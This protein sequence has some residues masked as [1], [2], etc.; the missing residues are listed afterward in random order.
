MSKTSQP[1]IHVSCIQS[2]GFVWKWRTQRIWENLAVD[3]HFPMFSP[4][5][6]RHL[7]AKARDMPLKGASF[8][9]MVQGP[10]WWIIQPWPWKNW[11]TNGPYD[12]GIYRVYLICIHW[13][14]SKTL[15]R[16]NV[17]SFFGWF[18]MDCLLVYVMD[19]YVIFV[20]TSVDALGV[21]RHSTHHMFMYQE[22]CQFALFCIVGSCLLLNCT[23]WCILLR[24]IF[25]D[26]ASLHYLYGAVGIKLYSTGVPWVLLIV[27]FVWILFHMFHVFHMF[28]CYPSVEQS[29]QL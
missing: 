24:C 12:T 8:S 16:A 5:F 27:A 2:R 11:M 1:A 3:H 10:K 28:H 7:T 23:T 15:S 4:F 19:G 22:V 14:F 20:N 13:G 29:K 17:R 21:F 9:N 25:A 18:A 26:L 6:G